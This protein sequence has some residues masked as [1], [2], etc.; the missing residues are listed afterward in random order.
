V[1]PK[2]LP[3]VPEQM[4]QAKIIL[5]TALN[6]LRAM[7]YA[8]ETRDDSGRVLRVTPQLHRGSH[9]HGTGRPAAQGRD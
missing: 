7:G 3:E 4:E 8:V 5:R 2:R 6:R 9:D 1:D